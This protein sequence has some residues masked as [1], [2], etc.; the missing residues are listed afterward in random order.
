MFF[1]DFFFSKGLCVL[2][3]GLC[4]SGEIVGKYVYN[5]I[6]V[7]FVWFKNV[8]W[9]DYW[10]CYY[11]NWFEFLFFDGNLVRVVDVNCWVRWVVK[12]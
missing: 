12:L 6:C 5:V 1:F 3:F 9:C 7:C 11:F 8:V 10:F 4:G 2:Y